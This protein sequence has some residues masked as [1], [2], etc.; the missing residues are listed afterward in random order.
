MLLDACRTQ[1]YSTHDDVIRRHLDRFDAKRPQASFLDR[2]I[3]L[4]LRQR[5]AELLLMRVDKMTMAC[6]VEARVPFL[7]HEFVRL[8]LAVPSS[9]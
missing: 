6:S 7:D 5:L 3:Y 4:E 2:M 8:A 1:R 9:L